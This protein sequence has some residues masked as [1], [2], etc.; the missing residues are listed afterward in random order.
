MGR[1]LGLYD[2]KMTILGFYFSKNIV[3]PLIEEGKLQRGFIPNS[4]V[5]EN[6]ICEEVIEN[7][8]SWRMRPLGWLFLLVINFINVIIKSNNRFNISVTLG[9]ELLG[10]FF[11]NLP[12]GD[13]PAIS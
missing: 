2:T 6:I 10:R 12:E 9:G 3:L 8:L 13:S 11:Q 1:D 5:S 7:P 4:K